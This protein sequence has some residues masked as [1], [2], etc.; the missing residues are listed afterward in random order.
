MKIV[1]FLWNYHQIQELGVKVALV[2]IKINFFRDRVKKN[3][4]V[5]SLYIIERDLSKN[6][7][8][9]S[10]KSFLGKKSKFFQTAENFYKIF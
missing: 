6:S 10:K 7:K 9:N 1:L 8:F 2:R 4:F 3:P 5:Y